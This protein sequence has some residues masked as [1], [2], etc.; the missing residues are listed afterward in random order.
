MHRET[1]SDGFT[2]LELLLVVALMGLAATLAIPALHRARTASIE[3]STVAS[4]HTL[5]SAQASYAATCANGV[6]PPA[7]PM[8]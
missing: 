3:A 7:R 1:N 2:L 4:L 6:F 8:S 5:V